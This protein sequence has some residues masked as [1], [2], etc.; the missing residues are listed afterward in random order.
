MPVNQVYRPIIYASL[1][2]VPKPNSEK[3]IK[4]GSI[5]WYVIKLLHKRLLMRFFQHY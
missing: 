4:Y 5:F 1:D 3:S 2:E